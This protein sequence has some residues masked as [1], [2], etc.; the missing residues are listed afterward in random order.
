MKVTTLLLAT[1]IPTLSKTLSWPE[2]WALDHES[3]TLML[4]NVKT[5]DKRT[6]AMDIT[7][8]RGVD[9]SEGSVYGLGKWCNELFPVYAAHGEHVMDMNGLAWI[10]LASSPLQFT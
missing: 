5:F 9:E 6:V 4:S 3:R 10:H 7:L 8:R 2:V 1:F